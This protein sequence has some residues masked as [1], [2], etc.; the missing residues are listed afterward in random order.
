VRVDASTHLLHP[1]S[2]A[3]HH[4]P[5]A[6]FPAEALEARVLLHLL[7]GIEAGVDPL[8]EPAVGFLP[9]PSKSI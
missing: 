2:H 7:V 8:L 5:E 6:L 1:R 4:P 3:V 9:I